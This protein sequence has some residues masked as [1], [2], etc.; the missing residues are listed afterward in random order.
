M[1]ASEF[2]ERFPELDP[3]RLRW[4]CSYYD[5]PID[6][7]AEYD[8]KLCWFLTFDAK[9]D[10][11]HQDTRYILY[12]LT[13]DEIKFELRRQ[14]LFEKYVGTHTTYDFDNCRN[15]WKSLKPQEMW[16][17]FYNNKEPRLLDYTERRPIGWFRP[18]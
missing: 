1:K 9:F 3:I 2:V 13:S 14:S 6:G 5:G 4:H 11:C 10:E 12:P 15:M 16:Y 8:G 17:N 18:W 7:I